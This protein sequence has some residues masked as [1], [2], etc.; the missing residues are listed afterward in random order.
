M[1]INSKKRLLDAENELLSEKQVIAELKL[2]YEENV[3]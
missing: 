1:F 3:T 2:R